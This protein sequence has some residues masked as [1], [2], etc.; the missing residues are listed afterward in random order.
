MFMSMICF[1]VKIF[2]FENTNINDFHFH[3]NIIIC[4]ILVYLFV[5]R[6]IQAK[7]IIAE[8]LYVWVKV[9]RAGYSQNPFGLVKIM[10]LHFRD[11]QKL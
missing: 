6:Q 7:S 9:D 2:Y 8:Q 10:I 3:T 11:I 5:R 4:I 1:S